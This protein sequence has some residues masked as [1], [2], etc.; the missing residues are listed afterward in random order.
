[1]IRHRRKQKVFLLIVTF[2]ILFLLMNWYSDNV[3]GGEILKI[4]APSFH[5]WQQKGSR[6]AWFQRLATDKKV[7]LHVASGWNYLSEDQYNS[8][9]SFLHN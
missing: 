7:P 8:K 5:K 3:L 1:M 6:V 2:T 4:I 9:V